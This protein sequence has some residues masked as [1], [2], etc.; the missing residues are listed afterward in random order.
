MHMDLV[1]RGGLEFV[2]SLEEIDFLVTGYGESAI[3]HLT[4]QKQFHPLPYYQLAHFNWMLWGEMSVQ[5]G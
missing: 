5:A 3:I 1:Q 4:Q 2:D